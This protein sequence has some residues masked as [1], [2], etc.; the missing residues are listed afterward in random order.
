MPTPPELLASLEGSDDPDA[1]VL[2]QVA[3]VG[4]DL[5]Q[6]H[7]PEFAFEA[8]GEA[9]A[10]A[11]AHELAAL[12]DSVQL[13]A[14]DAENPC[15]QVIAQKHM[16]LELSAL[17]ILSQEFEALAERHAAVYDGWGAEIVE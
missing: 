15:Y 4:A 14:P 12:D 5:R 16:L 6:P 10:L 2:L 3:H 7:S 13:H 8:D 17:N 11:L 9:S 1:L